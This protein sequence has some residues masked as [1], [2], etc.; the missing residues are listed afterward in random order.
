EDARLRARYRTALRARP[1]RQ[2]AEVVP[3]H[4]AQD[5]SLRIVHRS[6]YAASPRP[7]R[8]RWIR[9]IVSPTTALTSSRLFVTMNTVFP[10]SAEYAT[11]PADAA[12]CPTNSHVDTP[13]LVPEAHCRH[14]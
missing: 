1:V 14:T 9:T 13:R 12:I 5:R 10:T 3:A 7:S 11:N 8:R 2:A 4:A 6:R